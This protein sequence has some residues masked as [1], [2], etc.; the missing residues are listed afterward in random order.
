MRTP[1]TVTENNFENLEGRKTREI[2]C[3]KTKGG[4]VVIKRN[5][6]E[7]WSDHFT[8]KIKQRLTAEEQIYPGLNHEEGSE[9]NMIFLEKK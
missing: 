6:I 8:E 9:A 4:E 2:R 7:N 3:M 1:K 5:E